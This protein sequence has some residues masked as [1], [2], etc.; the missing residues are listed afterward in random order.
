MIDK[1]IV[2]RLNDY[3]I[4]ANNH[5][6]M[7]NKA[8]EFIKPYYPFDS[9]FKEEIKE[10][11]LL[12]ALDSLVFRFSKLQDWLGQKIFKTF[13]AYEEYPIEDISFFDVLKTLEKENILNVDVWAVFR[14]IRNELA[15]DYPNYDEIADNLNFIID[16]SGDLIEISKKLERE[17]NKLKKK[18]N[19]INK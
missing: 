9:N 2:N 8:I 15:H 13:L 11:V 6:E 3:F 17:F 12:F 7:I 19:E 1:M 14:E 5:I 10:D 16:N 4:V 18:K